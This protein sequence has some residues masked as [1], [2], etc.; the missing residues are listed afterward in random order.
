LDIR[1]GPHILRV[2]ERERLT[3]VTM[4]LDFGVR[5]VGS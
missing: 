4:A 5:L 3:S 2:S 1:A